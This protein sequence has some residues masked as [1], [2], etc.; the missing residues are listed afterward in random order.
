MKRKLTQVLLACILLLNCM[1]CSKKTDYGTEYNP[2]TDYQHSYE[3]IVPSLRDIQSDGKGQYIYKNNYIYYHDMENDTFLPL[4]NK[5][6]CLHDKE[7]DNQRRYECN[8]YASERAYDYGEVVNLSRKI[9]YYDG[10]VYYARANSLYRVSKDG[11]KR[12]IIF[13][14]KEELPITSWILHRG[15]FYYETQ[16]YFYGENEETDVYSK[17]ILRSLPLSDRMMEKDAKTIFES[18]EEHDTKNTAGTIIAYKDVVAYTIVSTSK[19]FKW[20]T[21]EEWL[22]EIHQNT[23]LYHVKSGEIKEIPVPEG[24]SKTVRIS[25]ISFLK[26]KMLIK[27]YDNLEDETKQF[28]IYSMDYDMDSQ[29]IWKDNVP[30]YM[31]MQVYGD[32]VVMLD[33]DYQYF[34]KENKENFNYEI[35]DENAN[36]MSEC[37]CLSYGANTVRGFGPDGILI[38]FEENNNSYNVYQVDF[39]EML[40][41]SKEKIQPKK[42]AQIVGTEDVP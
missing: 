41:C 31:E 39:E 11:S 30:Q 37:S 2:E 14:L 6:N 4:C 32:Y 10:Y 26:D 9:Q 15:V 23:Y 25:S 27:L 3:C 7:T 16:P 1:G 17:N 19:G 13:T 8:A 35:Y 38:L 5:A 20:E 18:D 34:M 22:E 42:I 40:K 24:Y 21:V 28:P 36:L 33:Q 29:Q 12:D